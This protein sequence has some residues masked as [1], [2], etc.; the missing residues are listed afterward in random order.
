MK[1]FNEL[2]DEMQAKIFSFNKD[3]DLLA[4][5]TVC[6][7]FRRIVTEDYPKLKK[8]MKGAIQKRKEKIKKDEHEKILRKQT[9]LDDTKKRKPL[10]SR[11]RNHGFEEKLSGHSNKCEFKTCSCPNI[12]FNYRNK[13]N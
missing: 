1:K 11:C 12:L 2:P 13:N 4:I 6:K 9:I 5:S 10:C 8:R 7:N 3:I